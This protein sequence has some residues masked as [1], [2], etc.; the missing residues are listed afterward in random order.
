M[1][2][3]VILGATGWESIVSLDLNEDEKAEFAKSADAV[4]SMNNAL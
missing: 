2:V 1:G 4:R 3:P